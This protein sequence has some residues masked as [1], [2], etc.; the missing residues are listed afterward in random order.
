MKDIL[1]TFEIARLCDVDIS[2]VINWINTGKLSAYKTPGNHRRVRKADFLIFL[3]NYRFP[4]PRGIGQTVLLV[5]PDS[6]LRFEMKKAV[7]KK[8][9]EVTVYEA[10]E[11]FM[12]G[13]LI[14]EKRPS[15]IVMDVGLTGMDGRRACGVIR[16]DRRLKETRILATFSKKLAGI[17][18]IILKAGADHFMMKPFTGGDFE[19]M[20]EKLLG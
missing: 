16:S 14:A 17:K 8:W 19:K 20:V 9:P 12:A 2:T 3:K 13:K 15:L 7:S 1:T 6:S 4:V 18:D 5:E 11:P 10:D